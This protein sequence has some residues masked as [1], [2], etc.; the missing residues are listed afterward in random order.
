MLWPHTKTHLL[1]LENMD[2]VARVRE[3]MAAR[4]QRTSSVPSG[5]PIGAVGVATPTSASS[6]ALMMRGERATARNIAVSTP[7][8]NT[9]A[10]HVVTDAVSES[11][12]TTP[13]A[14]APSAAASSS[15]NSLHFTTPVTSAAR[16]GTQGRILAAKLPS[17]RA[18]HS[19]H[20]IAQTFSDG[21]K[22]KTAGNSEAG[23]ATATDV[24]ITTTSA[25]STMPP[26]PRG[27]SS[28][29]LT[30]TDVQEQRCDLVLSITIS[31]LAQY[32]AGN[33]TCTNVTIYF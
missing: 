11:R 14:R 10:A 15:A 32:R 1:D 18:E 21:I 28:A 6:L 16:Q 25:S 30:N 2:E 7:S 23:P 3:R 31:T 13:F 5:E 26:L 17:L 27:A 19:T 24:T 20:D 9:P 4:R 12:P 8:G 22:A 29:R 33:S